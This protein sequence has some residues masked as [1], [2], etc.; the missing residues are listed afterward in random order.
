MTILTN[1]VDFLKFINEKKKKTLN[2]SL[3]HVYYHFI[4]II[5][6]SINNSFDK[7][8]NYNYTLDIIDIINILFWF[9]LEETKNIKLTMFLCDRA[10]LL[11][12]EYIIMVS[13]TLIDTKS[14][15]LIEV[16]LFVYK[17]TIG[18]LKL[19]QSRKL[20]NNNFYTFCY[21]NSYIYSILFKKIY[22]GEYKNNINNILNKFKELSHHIHNHF[23]NYFF[24]KDKFKTYDLTLFSFLIN[25]Q[26]FIDTLNI[27]QFM[28]VISVITYIVIYIKKNIS[29][30]D[31]TLDN[32]LEFIKK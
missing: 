28:D 7:L 22:L 1:E 3:K 19:N 9:L 24:T 6:S 18:A 21:I 5:Y 20:F 25:N 10:I 15:N 17:K 11:Y 27:N 26:P 13:N 2:L 16:K 32:N 14:I 12:T 8:L 4:K 31:K 30:Y 23:L 29:D